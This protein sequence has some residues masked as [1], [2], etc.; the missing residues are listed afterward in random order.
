MLKFVYK[1][2]IFLQLI[3]IFLLIIIFS[4]REKRYTKQDFSAK[5]K[6]GE[7][8]DI[9]SFLQKSGKSD[10]Y[11][12]EP[13]LKDDE[14]RWRIAVIQSG[15]FYRYNRTLIAVI[16]GLHIIGW[17][18]QPVNP[19]KKSAVKDMVLSLSETSQAD[20]ISFG[21]YYTFDWKIP[22][23]PPLK[24]KNILTGETADLIICL[25][26]TASIYVS[27]SPLL[28]I[29]VISE[30][31]SNSELSGL[32]ISDNDSGNDYVT[33]SHDPQQDIRQ[34]KLFHSLVKFRKLGMIYSD[35]ELGRSYGGVEA[36][37]E[38]SKILD[39][40]II[41]FTGVIEDPG[42]STLKYAQKKYLDGIN[43]LAPKIDALYLGIQGALTTELLPAILEVTNKYKIPVFAMEGSDFVAEGVLFGEALSD[44]RS[45]GIYNA[46]KIAKILKGHSPR[47]LNHIFEHDPHI[48]VNLK[49]AEIIGY[50]IPIDI[51]AGADEIYGS[52]S[53]KR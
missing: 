4:C 19:D 32:I 31:V 52:Q 45:L 18:D 49:A 40:D 7:V 38:L 44:M 20:F 22:D 51:I 34:F 14:K 48:A 1:F 36:A 11:G 23:V 28:K 42:H 37:E 43:Y 27:Q 2:K 10:K 30:S 39:F 21:E 35:T 29:P 46:V 15:D 5:E 9:A 3:L 53:K 25:G 6:S 16:E 26:S 17:L 24:L 47:Y 33:A 50:E 12:L 13:V 8:V 41:R